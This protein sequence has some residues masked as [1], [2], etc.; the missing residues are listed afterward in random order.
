MAAVAGAQAISLGKRCN[1]FD[2]CRA[3]VERIVPHGGVSIAGRVHERA[4]RVVG[5]GL[6]KNGDGRLLGHPRLIISVY[7]NRTQP[8]LWQRL[9][10]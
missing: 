2:S 4:C 10:G 1:T 5:V 3:S 9:L 8:G 7:G 6:R